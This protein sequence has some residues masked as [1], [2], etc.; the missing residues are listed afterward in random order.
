MYQ[1][2]GEDRRF[3]EDF[4]ACRVP[5]QAF[6]HRAH[7]RLAYTYLAET[8]VD[9]ALPLMRNAL[10]AFVA[11]NGIP[12]SKYHETLT[13]AWILAVHH[14]M[15]MSGA[16]ASADAFIDNHPRL[17]NTKIMLSHYSAEALFSPAARAQF[18]E[19]NLDPIP[20]HGE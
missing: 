11:H 14:F 17:L 4:E 20:R 6:D 8:N 15:S 7:V 5:P 9:T 1:V 19:P 2:S 16:A 12:A 10:R 3:R 13:H 18:V